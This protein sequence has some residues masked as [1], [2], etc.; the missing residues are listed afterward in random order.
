MTNVEYGVY[1]NNG[2]TDGTV[3]VTENI[4]DSLRDDEFGARIA[5]LLIRATDGTARIASRN[6]VVKPTAVAV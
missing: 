3:V 2:S 5:Q 4:N 1:Q 6:W